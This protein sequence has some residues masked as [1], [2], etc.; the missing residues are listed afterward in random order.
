ME[1]LNTKNKIREVGFPPTMANLS[2][3]STTWEFSEK[4][5]AHTKARIGLVEFIGM[6]S[7]Y[8]K[9]GDIIF[10]SVMNAV[11]IH[12]GEKDRFIVIEEN[13]AGVYRNIK[14]KNGKLEME[15]IEFTP[16]GDRILVKKEEQV[17]T[18]ESGLVIPTSTA[19]APA[20]GHIVRVGEGDH[21]FTIK[22]GDRVMF[23]RNAGV[24]IELEEGKF[25]LMREADIFGKF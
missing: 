22:E 20:T 8:V 16:L 1:L 9:P 11:P 23:G 10:Y 12:M 24:E 18:E 6:K 19:D 4:L 17:K 25:R 15:N 21:K 3:L 13:I 5:R 7:K 2:G 14:F